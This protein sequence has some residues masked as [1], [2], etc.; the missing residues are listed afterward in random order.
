MGENC[1]SDKNCQ[2]GL[3]CGLRLEDDNGN[4]KRFRALMDSCKEKKH[5]RHGLTCFNSEYCVIQM[6]Y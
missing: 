4:T 6:G 2:T 3:E 5:C 1:N